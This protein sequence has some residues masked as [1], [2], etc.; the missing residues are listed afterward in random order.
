VAVVVAAAVVVVGVAAV[1]AVDTILYADISKF[2]FKVNARVECQMRQVSK[3]KLLLLAVLVLLLLLACCCC[4]CRCYWRCCRTYYKIFASSPSPNL[5]RRTP[6]P[7]PLAHTHTHKYLWPTFAPVAFQWFCFRPL[8]HTVMLK[9]LLH[10]WSG[11]KFPIVLV[12]PAYE[13]IQLNTKHKNAYFIYDPREQN[14]YKSTKSG[15]G[16]H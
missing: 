3:D 16:T 7:S 5:S 13:D 1:A 4:C 10:I 15:E 8:S 11:H 2:R 14:K 12:P 6:T 9:K